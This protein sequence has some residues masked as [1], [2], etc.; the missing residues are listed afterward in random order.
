MLVCSVGMCAD[1][2]GYK[3]DDVIHV[4]FTFMHVGLCLRG[5]DAF[6]RFL[7]SVGLV[8]KQK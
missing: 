1:Q 8:A 7:L 3:Y 4:A 6:Q 5:K 2:K